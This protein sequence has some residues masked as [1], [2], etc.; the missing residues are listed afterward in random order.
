MFRLV[1]AV[2]VTPTFAKTGEFRVGKSAS[3][4]APFYGQDMDGRLK[5]STFELRQESAFRS[6]P[7]CGQ[8]H[9]CIWKGTFDTSPNGVCGGRATLVALYWRA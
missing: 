3:F 4:R 9:D 2:F 5:K 6:R 8:L 1:I 7:A